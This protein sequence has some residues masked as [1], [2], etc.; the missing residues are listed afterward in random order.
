MCDT[1]ARSPARLLAAFSLVLISFR[2]VFPKSSFARHCHT[3]AKEKGL[4]LLLSALRFLEKPLLP[5]R[6]AEYPYLDGTES[7]N[8]KGHNLD[9]HCTALLSF[10]FPSI[11][12][13]LWQRS[14]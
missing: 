1:A 10:R 14:L 8:A 11:G 6:M 12:R 7:V 2:V 13:K 9:N 5:P 4:Q 3:G